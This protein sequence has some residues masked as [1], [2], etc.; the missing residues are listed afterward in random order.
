LGAVVL[1]GLALRGYYA[2]S[3]SI[4]F[5]EAWSWRMSQ[6]PLGQMME[7]VARDVHPPLYY[8]ALKGWLAVFGTSVA[9]MRSLS[10]ACSAAAILGAYLLAAEAF[11]RRPGGRPGRGAPLLAAALV[12][13]SVF[14]VRYGWE[15]RMYALGTALATLS[16][17]SLLRALRAPGAGLWWWALYTGLALLF[18][19]THYYAL[20][21]LAGQGVFFVGY[22]LTATKGDFRTLA[23]CLGLR[24]GLLSFS[25]LALCWLPWLPVF[26]TQLARVQ[27]VF[28]TP[29]LSAWEPADLCY[30]MFVDPLADTCP[31]PE[32]LAV[33]LACLAAVA[34]LAW[35]GRPGEWCILC[36]VVIP[37]FLS[38]AATYCG[39]K[40]FYLRYFIFTHTL[41]L[42][43]IAGLVGR[44]PSAPARALLGAAVVVNFLYADVSVLYADVCAYQSTA[45]WGRPGMRGA[46]AYLA[47]KCRPG[48]PVVA[49]S[50]LSYFTGLYYTAGF[51]GC[52]MYSDGTP[53]VHY[54]GGS[55]LLPE[56]TIS[57][58]GLNAIGAGRVW[59][60]NTSGGAWGPQ[61]A[62]VPAHW[63]Q[64]SKATFPEVIKVQGTVVVIEYEVPHG[65]AQGP[66]GHRGLA[67]WP[68]QVSTGP[69]I[70]G[71]QG[72]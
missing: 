16:T 27:A 69:L 3:V 39:T 53:V 59:T 4:W 70:V 65:V 66:R 30:R 51:A 54:Y 63:R 44:A 72:R 42:V 41:L 11:E 1:A 7:H 13:L 24:T 61:I 5:D 26:L 38:V 62:P 57:E 48:E 14:Q 23:R 67:P 19:Y 18:A 28:W 36:G 25:V 32:S 64:R 31:R 33:A 43:G 15:V 60:L 22:C 17:W 10:L 37:F 56:D 55:I 20:F 45:A 58:D 21:T 35:N 12:A 40:V 50:T 68:G 8:L 6:F 46:A 71:S 29:P 9:A 47:S 34:A 49:S 2:G 52:R